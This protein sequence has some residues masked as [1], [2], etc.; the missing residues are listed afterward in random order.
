[1]SNQT[2]TPSELS[3]LTIDQ[4]F[5]LSPANLERVEIPLGPAWRGHLPG[6]RFDSNSS[7]GLQQASCRSP[8][9][10]D[11]LSPRSISPEDAESIRRAEEHEALLPLI[12][13]DQNGRPS[14]VRSIKR[15]T[16]KC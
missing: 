15:E 6:S 2:T 4:L 7:D 5:E 14:S 1:M 9:G 11:P 10:G 8:S 13:L 3:A 16:R 12:P